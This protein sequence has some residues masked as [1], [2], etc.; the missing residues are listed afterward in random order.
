LHERENIKKSP[1]NTNNK[2]APAEETQGTTRF[3]QAR[4]SETFASNNTNIVNL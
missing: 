1:F 3:S 4:V 2:F